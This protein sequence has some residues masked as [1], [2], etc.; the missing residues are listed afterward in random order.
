[1]ILQPIASSSAGNAYALHSTHNPPLLIEA[2]VSVARISEAMYPALFTDFAACLVTHEHGDHAAFAAKVERAGVPIVALEETLT[3]TGVRDGIAI[4]AHYEPEVIE[5][6]GYTITAI[7]GVH[8]VPVAIYLIED[9]D[10][11]VLFATDTRYF[12]FS[13]VPAA[14]IKKIGLLAIEANHDP[15]MLEGVDKRQRQRIAEFHMSIDTAEIYAAAVAKHSEQLRRVHLLHLSN[16]H[17]HE[18]DFVARVERAA[19]VP[20]TAAAERS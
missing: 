11:A 2:G 16:R 9:D 1:M 4:K 19:G 15:A 13:G 6:A 10:D 20:V 18:V 14:S 8:D 3:A 5:L 17:S 7:R 12:S